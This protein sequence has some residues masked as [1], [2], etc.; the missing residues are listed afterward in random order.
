MLQTFFIW[1]FIVLPLAIAVAVML[2][3]SRWFILGVAAVVAAMAVVWGVL[4]L[5]TSVDRWLGGEADA[6]AI[7]LCTEATPGSKPASY[8]L[9]QT[10]EKAG[11]CSKTS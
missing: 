7:V 4:T 5:A 2:Y 3:R 9:V 10:G 11:S 6:A 1:A 8:D